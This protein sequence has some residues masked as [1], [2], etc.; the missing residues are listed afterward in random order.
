MAAEK[1]NTFSEGHAAIRIQRNIHSIL[2][3]LRIAQ[4]LSPVRHQENRATI[5]YGL[6]KLWQEIVKFRTLDAFARHKKVDAKTIWIAIDTFLI[7]RKVSVTILHKT[8]VGD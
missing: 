8:W 6:V 5:F 3:S 7:P 1:S 4:C 2:S